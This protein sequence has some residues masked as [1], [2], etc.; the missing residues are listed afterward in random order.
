[1]LLITLFGQI[2]RPLALKTGQDTLD[3]RVLVDGSVI[4]AFCDGGRA[5]YASRS[6]PP[7]RAVQELGL[8]V[9]ATIGGG[10]AAGV[11][12]DVTVWEMGNMWL[13]PD[14]FSV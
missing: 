2:R 9:D 12:A 10:E 6:L 5:R 3:V 14:A 8:R 13:E 4:E 11:T 7:A 1:M